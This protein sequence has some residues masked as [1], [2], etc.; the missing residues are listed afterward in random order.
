MIRLYQFAP[1]LGLPNPSP[2]CMKLETYLRLAGLP[3]ESV[4]IDNPRRGP[5]GKLPFIEHLGRRIADSGFIIEYLKSQ[6]GDPLDQELTG[7]QRA[8]GHALR[9]MIEEGLYWVAVYARWADESGWRHTREAF[10]SGMPFP[11]GR[12]VPSLVRR[13][14]T[15]ALFMQGTGRHPPGEVYALGAA[16][17]AALA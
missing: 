2:F 14:M 12:F 3:Y 1:A 17:L 4:Y 6:F 16:D 10:F 15:R 7:E 11:L 5:K 13:G 9:R 8:L